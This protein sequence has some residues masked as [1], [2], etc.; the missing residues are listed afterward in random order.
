M[1]KENVFSYIETGLRSTAFKQHL[2]KEAWGTPRRLG[3]G[4]SCSEQSAQLLLRRKGAPFIPR[5]SAACAPEPPPPG[6]VRDLSETHLTRFSAG[7]CDTQCIPPSWNLDLRSAHSLPSFLFILSVA[8]LVSPDHSDSSGLVPLRTPHESAPRGFTVA[9]YHG[10]C[11]PAPTR[12]SFF[13]P[14][15]LKSH[16]DLS[17]SSKTTPSTGCSPLSLSPS[18]LPCPSTSSRYAPSRWCLTPRKNQRQTRIANRAHERE[19]HT[20]A[21]YAI[22]IQSERPRRTTEGVSFSGKLCCPFFGER[23]SGKRCR[24]RGRWGGTCY[25]RLPLG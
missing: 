24:W 15:G 23:I 25:T 20:M 2:L 6:K 13:F 4:L 16:H 22:Y 7:F 12:I 8:F 21:R 5:S 10:S 17:P 14:R 1:L 3:G 19:R 18:G 9:P 11:L